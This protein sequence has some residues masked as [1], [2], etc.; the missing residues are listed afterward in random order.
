MPTLPKVEIIM[1]PIEEQ[2][3]QVLNNIVKNELEITDLSNLILEF[4]NR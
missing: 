3:A 2:L 1:N 4:L